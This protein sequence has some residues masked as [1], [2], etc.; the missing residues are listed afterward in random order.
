V[1][2]LPV[3]QRGLTT[4]RLDLN[5]PKIRHGDRLSIES[6]ESDR[7]L[8]VRRCGQWPIRRRAVR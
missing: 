1:D 7:G 2:V 3:A 8:A 6:S 5:E 4:H